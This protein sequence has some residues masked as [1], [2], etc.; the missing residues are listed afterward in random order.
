[1]REA[2]CVLLL[3]AA[4]TPDDPGKKKQGPPE[5][6]GLTT[7]LL[8]GVPTGATTG[9]TTGTTTT[10]T[11]W[12]TTFDC[13]NRPVGPFPVTPFNIGTEE[14]FSFDQ[15]GHLVYQAGI[16]IMGADTTGT[17]G[18]LAT[19]APG[20]PA[21]MDVVADEQ[22]IIAGPDNGSLMQL[23]LQTGAGDTVLSGLSR[24]NTVLGGRDGLYY[25]S[26]Q[27]AG[28]VRWF[29]PVTELAG[30]AIT[31]TGFANGLALSPDEQTLYSAGGDTIWAVERNPAT[32]LWDPSTKVEFHS[33]PGRSIYAM[34]TDVCGWVYVVGFSDGNVS[35]ISPDGLTEENVA[36]LGGGWSFSGMNF[37]SGLGDW[38]VDALYVT[39]RSQV[40]GIAI[41]I[42]GSP[43]PS[44]VQAP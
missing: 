35:R 4:C 14:D 36:Q 22:L 2:L 30:P 11:P 17:A 39:N 9:P 3:A 38:A 33:F 12:T 8:T 32:G 7:G 16:T 27:N 42:P 15:A 6:T 37:G 24:P 19:G 44:D 5:H 28:R 29:D 13:V 41:G 43:G 23:D 1:M 31:D 26:E 40:F 25:I 34:D 21:G 18:V 20:D 10:T